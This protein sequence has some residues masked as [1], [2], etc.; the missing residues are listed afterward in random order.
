MIKR[1]ENGL[2]SFTILG[3]WPKKKCLIESKPSTRGVP[4]CT[5]GTH[6]RS[7]KSRAQKRY[8]MNKQYKIKNQFWKESKIS[9]DKFFKSTV[10]LNS[11]SSGCFFE[12]FFS[13]TTD[14]FSLHPNV[15]FQRNE[16]IHQWTEFWITYIWSEKMA[17]AFTKTVLCS[18][19]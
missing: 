5:H 18:D 6:V 10:C 3:H 4:T 13:K 11:F 12:K 17:G 2:Q 16:A 8:K 9:K 14:F 19:A 7:W 1:V 15:G